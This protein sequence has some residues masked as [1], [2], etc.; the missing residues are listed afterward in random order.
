MGGWVL[1]LSTSFAIAAAATAPPVELGSR[2]DPT[3]APRAGYQSLPV[4][5]R[6]SVRLTESLTPAR[7]PVVGLNY[8]KLLPASEAAHN[9]PAFGP[10]GTPVSGG[11]T[12]FLLHVLLRR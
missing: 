3:A 6:N 5:E 9:W 4:E 8:W 11:P 1:G 10:H 7:Q 2:I 12:L